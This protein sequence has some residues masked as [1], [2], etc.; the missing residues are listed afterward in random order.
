MAIAKH[1]AATAL[2]LILC[3]SAAGQ[4]ASPVG[5]GPAPSSGAGSGTVTSV[6]VTT[7]N[8]VSGTVATATTTPAISLT[9]GNITPTS[10]HTSTTVDADG[11][12]ITGLNGG[13]EGSVILNGSSTGS[14]TLGPSAA[15]LG[16]VTVTIPDVTD[17][18]VV[19][20]AAQTLSNKTFV[21]PVLGVASATSLTTGNGTSGSPSVVIGNGGGFFAP[22]S[23]QLEYFVGGVN[24]VDF[25]TTFSGWTFGAPVTAGGTLMSTGAVTANNG[26][27]IPTGGT[28]TA[29]VLFS[30]TANFGTFF[31]TGAPTLTAAKGS[32]YLENGTG[33]PYYNNNGTTGWTALSGGG[34]SGTVSNCTTATGIAYYAVTGTTVSCTAN[35]KADSSGNLTANSVVAGST[36]YSS[37]GGSNNIAVITDTLNGQPVMAWQAGLVRTEANAAI[38]WTSTNNA[39]GT[40][41][42]G[43]SRDAANVIDVGNGSQGD[44]SGKLKM[45]SLTVS[46]ASVNMP[47]LGTSSA[48][49]TGTMCWTTSTGLVNIDT[50]TTCLL[51]A[52]KFKQNVVPLGGGLS[53]VMAMRPVE[54]D[55]KPQYDPTHIGRQVGFIADEVQKI[56]P[57]LVGLDAKGEVHGMRY[58]QFTAVLAKAVQEQQGEIAD[59]KKQLAALQ[60][61]G[62]VANDNW[63]LKAIGWE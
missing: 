30:S 20:A 52:A 54:Y 61:G 18:L 44:A 41:D 10:V 33:I 24:R 51:S 36:S 5:P 42:T 6:S 19:L 31:G 53:E 13:N 56:D 14:L 45:A 55:L 35:L 16:T 9:L 37:T 43:L 46:G 34:G 11:P 8:G 22:A 21:A 38:S 4:V 23:G 40:A 58:E 3:G 60:S 17:T 63:F 39:T 59:L 29:G 2:L 26:T 48:A 25:G 7:A 49:T 32:L 1:L 50:T 62:H 12:L 57:R 15:A 27:A 28:S 47:G